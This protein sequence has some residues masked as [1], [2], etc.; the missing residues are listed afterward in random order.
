MTRWG[1]S[2][3]GSH[4]GLKPGTDEFRKAKREWVRK[5]RADGKDRW[6]PKTRVKRPAKKVKKK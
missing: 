2:K 5:W 6:T 4:I 3:Y 1:K